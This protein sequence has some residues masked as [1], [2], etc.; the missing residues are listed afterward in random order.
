MV[1]LEPGSCESKTLTDAQ[2]ATL[3]RHP[4]LVMFGDHLD[5]PTG[6][7]GF[8]WQDAKKDCE[9]LIARVS[10]AGGDASLIWPPSLGI[11][12]NSHLLMMD[13]NNLQSPIQKL[14]SNTSML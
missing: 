1:L 8:T 3:S 10:K 2:I 13:R 7:P 4:L 6:T 14:L 11:H 12:G 5:L 9:V